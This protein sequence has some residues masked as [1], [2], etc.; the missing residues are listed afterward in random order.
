MTSPDGF[1]P[2]FGEIAAAAL[3]I[4]P[5]QKAISLLRGPD[6]SRLSR[7]DIECLD[8]ALRQYGGMCFRE[9]TGLSH[10]AAWK[11][12]WRAATTDQVGQ[13]PMAVE[14]IAA[15]LPNADEIASHIRS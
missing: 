13:S 12:A 8:E 15:T 2:A 3:R 11:A 14:A 10:D 1:T 9:R 6:T 5:D 4:G 7:S